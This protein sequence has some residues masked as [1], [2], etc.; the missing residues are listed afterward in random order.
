MSFVKI[1]HSCSY[2]SLPFL[3]I[4][5][6]SL[7]LFSVFLFQLFL[8]IKKGCTKILFIII[9]RD[10]KGEGHWVRGGALRGM[11]N[12]EGM[13]EVISIK[14]DES[15]YHIY[16]QALI[17]SSSRLFA[18]AFPS[19]VFF[20]FRYFLLLLLL[21]SSSSSPVVSSS[22]SFVIFFFIIFSS[23]CFLHRHLLLL[24]FSSSLSSSP[25]PVVFLL[26]LLLLLFSSSSSSLSV[27]VFFFFSFCC[28]L[29]LLLPLFLSRVFS[30]YLLIISLFPSTFL[31][32]CV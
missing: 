23:S 22:S 30:Y 16:F 9:L 6:R 14:G 4:L 27:A 10:G 2:V 15:F 31:L 26:L 29:L 1:W 19:V 5:L 17:S 24:L 8:N 3:F 28:F 20:S 18:F 12:G 13:E 21:F 25:P 32:F 11:N 7:S